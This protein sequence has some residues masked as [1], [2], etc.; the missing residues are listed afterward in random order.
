MRAIRFAEMLGSGAPLHGLLGGGGTP[1]TQKMVIRRNLKLE[2]KKA[3]V[4]NLAG[5]KD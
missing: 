1:E 5:I 3:M 4:K 2:E